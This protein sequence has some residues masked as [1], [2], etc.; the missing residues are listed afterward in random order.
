VGLNG[1]TV[2]ESQS[3]KRVARSRVALVLSA[4]MLATL[5]G[6]VSGSV[7]TAQAAR[8]PAVSGGALVVGDTSS[9]QKLDPDVVTN[10]LDFQALALIYDQLVQYNAKLQL[11][12]DLATK[13]TYSNGN[14]LLTFQL[15]QGV[16]F[17]D[18]TTFTS[19]NVVASLDRARAPKTGDASASFLAN[20]KKIVA[21]GPY[22]VQF[23]MSA[24]DSSVLDGLTSVNLS[25]LSTKAITAGTLAKTPDGTGPFAFSSW[26]PDNSFVMKAN[27]SYW[28]GKVSLGSVKIETIP[29]E[30]SIASAVEANTVQIGLLTEPQIATHLPSPIVGQKVLDLTYRALM[31]QDKSGPLANVDNRLAIACAVNRKDVL[32]E[33]VFGAGQVVGPVPLGVFAS[34]VSAVCP[35]PNIAMA[36]SYLQKAG[37]PNGFSFTA[38]TSTDLDPTSAAQATVM[39]SELAQA[40]ITM[41]PEN[42]AGDAYIQD[43][44][45]GKF[46]AAFAWNGADPDP[47]TMYG[48]YF[49]TGANLGVPAGYSSPVLQKLLAQG[50]T[51]SSLTTRKAI[52]TQFSNALT[53]N[54]VW[55]WLFTAYDYAAVTSSVHG[56]TLAPTNST[57][58]ASLRSTT[59]S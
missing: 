36:K 9:V 30:Q 23:Q 44:L 6:V 34:P 16:T 29:S 32:N 17:D 18:G 45:K 51:A 26:S 24:P 56:F 54:A 28:G 52:W 2:L 57:S 5:G 11:V 39:Q 20:V 25:M 59:L 4:G 21:T 50:D 10:F 1:R 22:T 53:S 3:G 7:A 27:P 8:V 12:P 58:L 40:G 47:Y 37:D 15:R 31:L 43:W 38:L 14:K 48:R 19:A 46:Q 55:I 33:A 35:T 42:I 49:G 13:W 41:H